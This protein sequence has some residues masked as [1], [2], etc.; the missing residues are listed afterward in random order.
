MRGSPA[1]TAAL[2]A[3]T[4]GGCGKP[5]PADRAPGADRVTAG[6]PVFGT[7]AVGG[8]PVRA[9]EVALLDDDHVIATASAA[10]QFTIGVPAGARPTRL[11]VRLYEP[12]EGAV[13]VP[14]ATG[15]PTNVEIPASRIAQLS[16]DVHLPGGAAIDGVELALTPR[17]GDVTPLAMLTD[18]TGPSTRPA[19]VTH[20]LTA[21]HFT[22][23]VVTGTWQIRL[24]R[25]TDGPLG[26][27]PPDLALDRLTTSGPAPAEA[28][29]G[30]M[31]V[32][33]RDLHVDATLR[34]ASGDGH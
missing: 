16:G 26:S 13:V 10:N 20:K 7:L 8:E 27:T 3:L 22:E 12:V 21:A 4:A 18:G 11:L 31:V 28:P 19:L 5:A 2:A 32:V 33:D 9:A 14:A 24:D 23:R 1:L 15:H 6:Q 17:L 29:G 34:L 30:P 25:Q